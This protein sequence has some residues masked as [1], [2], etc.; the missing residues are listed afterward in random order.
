MI[1]RDNVTFII[2]IIHSL[3]FFTSALTDGF[4]II[5]IIIIGFLKSYNCGK[6]HYY[7]I[8][9]ITG[10]HVI[11]YK[12]LVVYRNTWYHI[13]VWKTTKP[14]MN[15]LNKKCKYKGTMNVIL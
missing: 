9:I 4:I 1:F 14:L 8:E 7:K 2:I 15:Q 6:N 5:I 11:M 10:N 3:E 12:L 13:I